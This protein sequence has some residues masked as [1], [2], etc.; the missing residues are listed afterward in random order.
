MAEAMNVGTEA[1]IRYNVGGPV[2]W[3][4][5]LL[6]AQVHQTEWIVVTPDFDLFAEERSAG[7]NADVIGIR[8]LAAGGGVPPSVDPA[9]IY[10]FANIITNAEKN[11]LIAEARV[12]AQAE[13]VRRGLP[14]PAVAVVA[15]AA[16]PDPVPP[17]G[18]AV[19][20]AGGLDALN[21]ALGLGGAA[22]GGSAPRPPVPEAVGVQ[23]AVPRAAVGLA[24]EG[25]PW[26]TTGDVRSFSV[27]LDNLGRR[28]RDLRDCSTLM[29]EDAFDDWP[30]RGPRTAPWRF[31][32]MI[33]QAGNPTAWHSKWKGLA[34]VK[35][36]D[37]CCIAHATA[38]H[39]LE[40]L[41]RFD[42]LNI[43]NIA[44]AE[45]LSRQIQ[46]IEERRC[47]EV[48]RDES[49]KK[50]KN[51]TMVGAGIDA[52]LYAW[53]IRP[54]VQGCAPAPC[55]RTG[56]R[57]SC[58][59]SPKFSRNAGKP[60]RSETCRSPRSEP[61][62]RQV[63]APARPASPVP[64]ASPAEACPSQKVAGSRQR[65][66]FPFPLLTTGEEIRQAGL[67]RSLRTRLGRRLR[68]QQC[69]GR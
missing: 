18:A 63:R 35:D 15:P 17:A 32:H 47:E 41:A 28:H 36:T 5:R 52:Y 27:W 24:L 58:R 44:A 13:R 55:R 16:D 3:H 30:V 38:C 26:P 31:K 51:D 22:A 39:T 21:A 2:V 1:L 9:R 43:P 42:Q 29:T 59:R 54:R 50:Q 66:I 45:L 56:S 12:L 53:A 48:L 49:G 60:V 23:A 37:G 69:M 6:L 11:A 57:S 33:E 68:W 14:H 65:N 7:L 20:R 61:S 8:L 19:L 10:D 4:K 40:L 62:G 67:S 34:G 25:R 46:L 64:M